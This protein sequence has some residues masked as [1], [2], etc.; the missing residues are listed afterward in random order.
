MYYCALRYE[1]RFLA[2]D[3]YPAV[4][5][6]QDEVVYLHFILQWDLVVVFD[7]K[8]PAW[9]GAEHDRR[10]GDDFVD[11]GGVKTKI[12]NNGTYIA[13]CAKTCACLKIPYVVSTL[14]ADTQ[15]VKWRRDENPIIVTGDSDILAYDTT[16]TVILISSWSMDSEEFRIYDIATVNESLYEK[17][18]LY[19][20]IC[21]FGPVSLWV[22]AAVCGCDFSPHASGICGIGETTI[23]KAFETL[24][25]KF[26]VDGDLIYDVSLPDIASSLFNA[27]SSVTRQRFGITEE[28]ISA[29]LEFISDCFKSKGQYYNKNGDVLSMEDEIVAV[30]SNETVSH[31]RGLTDPKTGI[32]F[33]EEEQYIV[34]EYDPS[35]ELHHSRIRNLPGAELPS[36]R[37]SVSD[38]TGVEL[39][40]MVMARGGS[41]TSH[42]GEAIKVDELKEVSA[43]FLFLEEEVPSRKGY[44]DRNPQ[45]NGI[46]TTIDTSHGK[47][48]TEI[49][50]RLIVSR[51]MEGTP[52]LYFLKKVT[53]HARIVLEAPEIT[54]EMIQRTFA[55]SGYSIKA[56]KVAVAYQ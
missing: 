13:L 16:V 49:V 48:I 3:Y 20:A 45:T 41:V 27:C 52:R 30:S 23:L 17:Y 11:D 34:D 43:A 21:M 4:R 42:M 6:F 37:A 1:T 24:K 32:A 2:N 25:E 54:E 39:K 44:F 29:E 8:D 35:D 40:Q 19:E 53:D 26:V 9:K 14:E 31:M 46:F 7:G 50:G 33:T 15:V 10:Y 51:E 28:A 38:C 22:W 12:R 55:H 5:A 47:N 36:N 56:K 18:P